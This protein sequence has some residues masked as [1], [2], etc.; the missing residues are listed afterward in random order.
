M[1]ELKILIADDHPLFRAA[2]AQALK[3]ISPNCEVVET[4][5]YQQAIDALK[6]QD[7]DLAL[8]DLSMPGEQ[9]V[10]HLAEMCRI[11]PDVVFT[12]ISG[13]D[14]RAT[15]N[16]VRSLGASGFIAKSS[17]M[18]QLAASLQQVIEHGECWPQD[19][20]SFASDHADDPVAI[21]AQMTP[22]QKRVLAMIADGKL[23]KQIAYDL[24]IQE[25][26]IKQHVSAILR[27]LGVY[28]RTQAGLIYQQ[29]VESRANL[30][31]KQS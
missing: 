29:A 18:Q 5:D 27:K 21:I 26:T 22:Q 16:R 2:L 10:L 31:P 20:E 24:N 6:A 23:N 12:V 8:I 15:I 9:G 13:H 25:T 7:F 4:E 11:Y 30:S 1:L 14:D 17:S 19:G 3:Q 28:N